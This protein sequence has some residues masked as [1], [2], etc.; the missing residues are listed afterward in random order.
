MKNRLILWVVL[1]VIGFLA[2]F[3]PQYLKAHQF[4]AELSGCQTAEQASR[5]RDTASMMYLAATQK[6]FG[7]SAGYAAQFFNQAQ[8]VAS[9]TQDEALRNQLRDVLSSRDQITAD[10]AKGDAAVVSEMQPLLMKL[11]GK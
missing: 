6:N 7:I 1:L 8:K 9:S 10:L 3:I 5:V 2:G 11:A 4:G